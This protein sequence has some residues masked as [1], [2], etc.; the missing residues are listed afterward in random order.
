MVD[1]SSREQQGIVCV[2]GSKA[3]VY[4]ICR[5][6]IE[7]EGNEEFHVLPSPSSMWLTILGEVVAAK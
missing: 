4:G 3:H 5:C 1:D 2:G 6:K 7:E